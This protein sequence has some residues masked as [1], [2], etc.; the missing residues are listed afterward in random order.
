[1]AKVFLPEDSITLRSLKSLRPLQ[2]KNFELETLNLKTKY[3]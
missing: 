3:E 1:M 2:K